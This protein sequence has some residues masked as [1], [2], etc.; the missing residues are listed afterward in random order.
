MFRKIPPAQ[1]EHGIRSLGVTELDAVNFEDD[2][3]LADLDYFEEILGLVRKYYPMAEIR[4]EN[5]LDPDHLNE[6]AIDLLGRNRMQHLNISIGSANPTSLFR[7]RRALSND[8][9]PGRVEQARKWGMG[10]TL[11]WICGLEDD[12]RESILDTLTF[13]HGLGS[14]SGISLFYPV[15]GLDGFPPSR[16]TEGTALLAKGS[17]AYPWH[18]SLSTKEMVTAFRLSRLV[19][20][21]TES[22]EL[23]SR[24][25][26]DRRLLTLR[27]GVGITSLET[28]GYDQ[29]LASE[30]FDRL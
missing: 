2:S 11:Y 8:Q 3:L 1:F 20:A 10:T 12:T 18:G 25:F 13:I 14:S 19:T 30:F 7:E 4:A 23:S 6:T 5:G 24:C 21:A 16:F 15:P 17:S 28:E 9:L 27:K 29:S 22:D 26:A